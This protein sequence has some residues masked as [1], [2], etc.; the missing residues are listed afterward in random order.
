M[1]TKRKKHKGKEQSV[2]FL[3]Y[4]SNLEFFVTNDLGDKQNP[5]ISRLTQQTHIKSKSNRQQTHL[6]ISM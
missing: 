6:Y 2:E 1:K 3:V 4:A 5:I